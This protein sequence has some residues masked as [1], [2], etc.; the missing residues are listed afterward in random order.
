MIG[1][2]VLLL[3]ASAFLLYKSFFSSPS[4]PVTTGE[5]SAG[6]GAPV[7][8]VGQTILPYGKVL[9]FQAIED[10]NATNKKIIYPQVS[11]DEVGVT[12]GELIK[13]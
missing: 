9:N 11:P 3:G 4:I 8:V 10:Y 13:F 12:P 5:L 1:V 6:A 7:P 2:S